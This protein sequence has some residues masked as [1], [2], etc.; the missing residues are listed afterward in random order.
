[1]QPERAAIVAVVTV[2]LVAL[3][4]AGSCSTEGDVLFALPTPP[5]ATAGDTGTLDTDRRDTAPVGEDV[6]ELNCRVE[7]GSCR[8]PAEE[9]CVFELSMYCAARGDCDA[10]GVEC[11]RSAHCSAGLRCCGQSAGFLLVSTC[12]VECPNYQL[13]ATDGECADGGRCTDAAVAGFAVC[14]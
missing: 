4:A 8:F 3:F 13:C 6:A 11:S 2:A 7:A 10:G 9:C 1:M 12:R 5:D 14:E